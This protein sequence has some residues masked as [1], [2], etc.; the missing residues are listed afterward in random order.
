MIDVYWLGDIN[1]GSLQTLVLVEYQSMS[2]KRNLV[3]YLSVII[4]ALVVGVL[5]VI[6]NEIPT[7]L[8][9]NLSQCLR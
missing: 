2:Q 9:E 5:W 1:V 6:A 4:S 3:Q 7:A 8:R